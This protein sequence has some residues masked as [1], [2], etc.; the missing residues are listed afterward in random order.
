MISF[1]HNVRV[2]NMVIEHPPLWVSMCPESESDLQFVR[3]GHGI[4]KRKIVSRETKRYRQHLEIARCRKHVGA[5]AT[6][7]MP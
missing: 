5:E 1:R 3:Y 2:L 7:P 4:T 6:Y